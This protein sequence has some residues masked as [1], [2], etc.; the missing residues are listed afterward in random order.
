MTKKNINNTSIYIRQTDHVKVKRIMYLN[1]VKINIDI[2]AFN[3]TL[4]PMC[5]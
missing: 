3:F 2:N 1:E 5:E 4:T